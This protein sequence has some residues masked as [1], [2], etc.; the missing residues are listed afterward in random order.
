VNTRAAGGTSRD[1]PLVL[2]V[3]G[4]TGGDPHALALLSGAQRTRRLLVLRA[5]LDAVCGAP[6]GALPAGAADRM[7]RDWR[8]LEAADRAGPSAPSGEELTG[9]DG[10]CTIRSPAPGP[11]A[12]CGP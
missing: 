2:P 3:L 6:P 4:S 8:L 12:A 5:V 9:A 1:L 7:L 10:S 11:S